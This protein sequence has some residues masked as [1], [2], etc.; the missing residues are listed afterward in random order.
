MR[1]SEPLSKYCNLW[2]QWM[3]GG[4][5]KILIQCCSNNFASGSWRMSNFTRWLCLLGMC[6]FMRLYLF[7]LWYVPASIMQLK[8]ETKSYFLDITSY[9]TTGALHKDAV[10]ILCFHSF[11]QP[12]FSLY[13]AVPVK[14]TRHF[15]DSKVTSSS[16]PQL[17]FSEIR[18]IDWRQEKRS[19]LT[20][21]PTSTE[22]QVCQCVMSFRSEVRTLQTHIHGICEIFSAYINE[23]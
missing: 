19:F 16:G 7:I 11:F 23:R 2:F 5:A 6:G 20:G 8:S 21:Y 13:Y 12:L 1:G 18:V 17:I 22:I 9:N 3:V 15:H 14:L 10:T 4:S